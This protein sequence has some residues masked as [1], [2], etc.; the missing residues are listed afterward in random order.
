MATATRVADTR[1]ASEVINIDTIPIYC[2]NV[3]TSMARR[4]RM[5]DRFARVGLS[6]AQ[7]FDAVLSSSNDVKEYSRMITEPWKG[8]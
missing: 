5:A 8:P 1:P 6:Q 2:I 4:T 7:F 3:A